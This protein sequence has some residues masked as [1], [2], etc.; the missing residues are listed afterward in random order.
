M[1][2]VEMLGAV[3]GFVAAPADAAQACDDG[4]GTSRQP[5][6]GQELRARDIG[7]TR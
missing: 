1:K 6:I 7:S 3:A 2:S 5:R 4:A